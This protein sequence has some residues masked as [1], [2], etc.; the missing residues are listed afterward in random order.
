[1][2]HAR[3][4][5]ITFIRY[6]APYRIKVIRFRPACSMEY[7][8]PPPNKGGDPIKSPAGSVAHICR[9]SPTGSVTYRRRF[10]AT[11][12]GCILGLAGI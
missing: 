8:P 9:F 4:K 12:L 5:R 2:E 6:G 7:N 1:M 3:R 10:S 11:G